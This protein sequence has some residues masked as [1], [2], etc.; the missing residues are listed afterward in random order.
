MAAFQDFLAQLLGEGRIIFRSA[1]APDD[2]PAEP[3]L[4]LLAQSFATHALT[5]AGPPIEF[6]ARVACAAA[7]LVRQASWALINHQDR[8]ADLKRRVVMPGS[9]A[10][11]A[12]HLS[13][14]L[15]L[16][17]LPQILKRARGL[18]PSDPL[19]GLLAPV[20]RRWPLSGILSD[21]EEG[22]LVS[23]DFAGHRGLQLLYAERLA[24]HDRP[25]WRPDRSSPA[26]EPYEL[27]LEERAAP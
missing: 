7:E 14:D 11:P 21:V 26:W 19:V 15:L 8:L 10:T 24:D 13:A 25:A 16:R 27:V 17:Y 9:P 20:L 1:R 2:R 3:D 22:P 18:D 6:E 4:T 5:V 23:L 12:Q